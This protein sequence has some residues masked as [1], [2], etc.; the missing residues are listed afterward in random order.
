MRTRKL[1]FYLLAAILS[2]C[3]PVMSLHPLYTEKDVVFDEKLLGT[4][5]D[6]PNSPDMTWQFKRTDKS[7]KTYELLVSGDKVSGSFLAH[8]VKL[9]NKW[10]LDVYP[11]KL[12]CEQQ[13][14]EDMK[15]GY[16]AFFL[17][18]VHTFIKVDLIESRLKI[19]LTMDDDAEK[20][21]KQDPNA[22]KHE[23][24]KDYSI[25]LTAQTKELQEFVIKYAEDKRLFA[26]ARILIL[27]TLAD[28]NSLAVNDP[29]D[30]KLKNS[31]K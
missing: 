7:D 17:L 14:L 13:K 25:V 6:D 27:K 5:V 10:F 8:L 24:V 1:L 29:N 12:P 19:W 23:V 22:V 26:D 31:R 2:G 18:S 30:N 28:P 11:N 20:L 15:W 4:W 16:N 9:D 21:L 3:V